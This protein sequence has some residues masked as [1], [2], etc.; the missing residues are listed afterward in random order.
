MVVRDLA[1][2]G[3]SA[4]NFEKEIFKHLWAPKKKKS[5]MPHTIEDKKES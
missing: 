4:T 3:H 2:K 5:D 1:D